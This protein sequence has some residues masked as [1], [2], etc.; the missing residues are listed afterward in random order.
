MPA[1]GIESKLGD[2]AGN[3]PSDILKKNVIKYKGRFI[4]V[5]LDVWLKLSK[6]NADV[7]ITTGF[8]PTF[9]LAFLWSKVHR[10]KHIVMTD[11]WLGS[12]TYL[13]F[14][15]RLI[16]KIIYR[17]SDA[18]IGASKHSL[19]L[20]RSYGCYSHALF[21]SHLCADN[22]CFA[23]FI[24]EEK[25]YDIMFSGQFIKRKMPL[26]F[27][28]VAKE[29]KETRG[30]C[31]ALIIGSGP[32]ENIFIKRLRQYEIDY[33][34]PGFAQQKDLPKYYAMS[35]LLLF[36]SE[37]DPWG[38]V[39]NEACAVGV[40]VLTCSNTGCANDLIIDNENGFV[41]PLDARVWAEKAVELLSNPNQ[42]NRVS[43]NG[44]STVKKFNYGNAAQGLINAINYAS[45]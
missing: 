14:I 39:A 41:L 21:Q 32:M 3:L 40:P 38:I 1:E 16:R 26:F 15:H 44:L 37:N 12:E 10:K 23:K 29:I 30:K 19:D 27:C 33:H 45:S 5:N 17:Y 42:Y 25:K 34:Y 20:F 6:Y 35:N 13:S 31:S 8:N 28:E 9:L 36:P 11:G 43:K 4:H 7:V 18:F 22:E 24:H 2:A